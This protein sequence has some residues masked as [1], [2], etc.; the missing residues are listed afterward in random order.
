MRTNLTNT[1][2]FLVSFLSLATPDF[3]ENID[4]VTFLYRSPSIQISGFFLPLRVA[5]C[6]LYVG[7]LG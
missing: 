6:F 2:L 7:D 5:N 3:L 1:F 4:R